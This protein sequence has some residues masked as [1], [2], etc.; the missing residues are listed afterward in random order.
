MWQEIFGTGLVESAG[1]FGV[2][3]ER[4]S[5]QKL[6]D[7]LA[8]EFRESG[9][10]VKRMYR[11]LVLSATYRQSAQVT[12]ELLR[13]DPGN[14]LL[15]RGPRFRMD[16]EEVRDSVLAVSGLLVEK[17]G[18][19]PVKPYQPPGLW[20]EVAMPESNTKE[21]VADHGEN[22][23]RRSVYTF[24]KRASPPPS[25]ETFDATT[26]ET[27]CPRRARGDTPLQALVT[28]NDPQYVEAARVLAQKALRSSADAGGRMET[29]A[30]TV[31]GRS[32]DPEE[33][34]IL[35]RSR[36]MFVERFAAQ[37]QRAKELLAVGEA[38]VDRALNPS[39]LAAWTMVA[40]QFLNLDE[41]LTK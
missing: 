36:Q 40:S 7:W 24:L 39:E 12:P 9:W 29:M 18:G 4:P 30:R 37:P 5:N 1:D 16:A 35:E 22:L 41:F 15:A 26:R 13:I 19:P 34:V 27:A 32:L 20:Q 38:P 17:I 6:L 11:S 21:Y 31:L 25:L 28:L 23:Y 14:R 33:R 8:V 3:G 2:M 10:D